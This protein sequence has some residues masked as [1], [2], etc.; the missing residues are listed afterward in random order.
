MMNFQKVMKYSNKFL[1]KGIQARAYV[2]GT[3]GMETLESL[4][5]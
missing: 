3:S 5:L 1:F 2:I 4:R